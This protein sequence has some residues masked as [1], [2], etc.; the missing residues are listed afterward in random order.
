MLDVKKKFCFIQILK[1]EY[2]SKTIRNIEYKPPDVVPH[3]K[4]GNFDQFN[5]KNSNI[6]NI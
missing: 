1:I 2:I 5:I 6:I 4:N 3:I